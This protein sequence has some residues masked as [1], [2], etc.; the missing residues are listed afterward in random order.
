MRK[1][2]VHLGAGA[3]DLDK[4]ANFRCGFTEFIKKN[5]KKNDK[6]FC[7]E[8]NKFNIKKLKLTYKKYKNVKIL[9]IGIADKNQKK[10]KFFYT[11]QD[12]PH[13]QVTS[14]KKDH[15][16]KHYPNAEIKHF[17]TSAISINDFFKYKVKEKNIDYLSIDLEGID[18]KILKSIDLKKYNISNI[19][20]EYLHL[21]NFQKKFLINYLLK[22][23][24]S[25]F[26]FGYDHNNFD[27]LFKKKKNY[28]NIFLSKF[29]LWFISSKHLKFF[30]YF[31]FK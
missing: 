20:I 29:F 22:N 10:I 31:I 26:G 5:Y 18:F 24:Y 7:A 9:N 30:N 1:I 3:G 17:L 21:S 8:V 19:S 12:S 27:Y 13:F 23:G 6:I 4:R 28:W 11:L 2:F 16:I 25:Y 14:L 15:V